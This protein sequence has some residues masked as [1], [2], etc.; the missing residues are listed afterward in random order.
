[1]IVSALSNSERDFLFSFAKIKEKAPEHDSF[2]MNNKE[3]AFCLISFHLSQPSTTTHI[4]IIICGNYWNVRETIEIEQDNWIPTPLFYTKH[5]HNSP[6]YQLHSPIIRLMITIISMMM[7]MSGDYK[8]FMTS[9][10]FHSTQSNHPERI[11]FVRSLSWGIV[12]VWL[13]VDK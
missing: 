1:M 2:G 4:M 6:S 3:R 11:I 13:C 7:M 10:N 12:R 8:C 5:N 9:R